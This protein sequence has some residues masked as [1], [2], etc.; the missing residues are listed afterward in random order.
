MQDTVFFFLSFAGVQGLFQ[1][2]WQKFLEFW[3]HQ[4]RGDTIGCR[5]AQFNGFFFH[6]RI[7]IVYG[8]T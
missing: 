1:G 7:Y 8:Q 4:L 5:P 3:S 6:R 2:Y